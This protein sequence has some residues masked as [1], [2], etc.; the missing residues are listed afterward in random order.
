MSMI[1]NPKPGRRLARS[2]RLGFLAFFLP[3]L[4]FYGMYKY[5]PIIYSGVLSFAKWNFVG[6]L[7]WVGWANYADMFGKSMFASGVGNTFRYIVAFMP[8]F[9][10]LPLLFATMVLSVKNRFAQNAYKALLFLPTVLALS[11]VCM[12]WLWIYAPSFGVLNVLLKQFGFDQ[13]SWLS[14]RSTAFGAIVAVCSWK[15]MGQNLILFTAGLLNVPQEC[16][17]ASRID[18]ANAWQ[19]FFR[20]KLPLI[21]PIT[22]YVITTSII[23]AADRAF[24]AIHILTGGGPSYTTTNLAYVIYEFAFKS[25]NIG[26]ASAI[27]VFTSLFYLVITV[28]MMR[29]MGGFGKHDN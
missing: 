11:I 29:T 8:F 22:V 2:E 19:C 27:A 18:G 21:M 25:Y 6:D 24:T 7:K 9:V 13:I 5:F 26:M 17:E 16:I 10:V 4:A 1:Q 3:A 14:D 15:Y 28:V 20:I 23:F 12:V